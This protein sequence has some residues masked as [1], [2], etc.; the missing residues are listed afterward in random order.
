MSL[1]HDTHLALQPLQG[2]IKRLCQDN[3]GGLR[4]ILEGWRI[5]LLVNIYLVNI[6]IGFKWRARSTAQ[7]LKNIFSCRLT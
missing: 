4:I 7:H 3:I 1:E 5:V 6:C 2:L